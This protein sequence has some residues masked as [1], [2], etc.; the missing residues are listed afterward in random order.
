[1]LC[2][3]T[4]GAWLKVIYQSKPQGVVLVVEI[5]CVTTLLIV[6]ER[7]KTGKVTID[8]VGMWSGN[9][10]WGPVNAVKDCYEKFPYTLM[11][12][13]PQLVWWVARNLVRRTPA[14]AVILTVLMFI[15]G[16]VLSYSLLCGMSPAGPG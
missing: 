1:M 12:Y 14:E 6:A 4:A 5:I 3:I 2:C 15:V 10:L 13:V 11:Y 7:V 16:F 9:G 8:T